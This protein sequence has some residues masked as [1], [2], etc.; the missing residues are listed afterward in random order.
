MPSTYGLRSVAEVP[1]QASLRKFTVTAWL[2]ASQSPCSVTMSAA[3]LA[4]LIVSSSGFLRGYFNPVHG[5]AVPPSWL[6]ENQP[7][8]EEAPAATPQ[9]PPPGPPW[10]I[11]WFGNLSCLRSLGLL[12]ALAR[13]MPAG[14]EVVLRGRPTPQLRAA[15][16]MAV[17][18][19]P[20]LVFLGPYDRARDLAQIH[21][22][23]HFAWTL[24]FDDAGTNSTWLLPNRLYESS[25]HG[26]VPMALATDETGRWLAAHGARLLLDEPLEQTV[27]ARLAALDAADGA[28]LVAALAPRR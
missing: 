5:S 22:G 26:V 23:L 24:D 2:P 1:P 21:A 16:T 19:T 27:P 14:V 3:P 6:L 17:A 13:A 12:A 9:P 8:A 15:V 28:A 7:L 11:G 18:R 10:R 20:G 25:L 4:L